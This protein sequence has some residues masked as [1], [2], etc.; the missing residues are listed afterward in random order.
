M[1]PRKV[2]PQKKPRATPADIL[3]MAR[4]AR[5]S[6]PLA[7]HHIIARIVNGEFRI[8]C[9]DERSE[10]LCRL[11]RSLGR[12]DWTMLGYA[13]MSNHVHLLCRAGAAPSDRLVRS[14]HSGF[15]HWLNRTQN[16]LGPVFAERHTTNLVPDA[17]AS[18][19]LAYIHNNPVRAGVAADA[20]ETTWTSHRAYLGLEPAPTWLA[21]EHGLHYSGF[22]A[23]HTGRNAF[24]A[25]A[26]ERMGDRRD[27]AFSGDATDALRESRRAA[28]APVRITD[29]ALSTEESPRRRHDVL[30]TDSTPLRPRWP[31]DV[32][33]VVTAAADM[34][35]V[36]VD[37]L[38]SRRRDRR[39]VG[40]RRLALLVWTGGLGRAQTEM[41]Q[42]L[43]LT[44]AG[45][46][47]LLYRSDAAVARLATQAEVLTAW[48]WAGSADSANK[49]TTGSSLRVSR[50]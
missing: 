43:G 9:D 28:G 16:R 22:D 25:F 6:A 35:G 8:R 50:T 24:H 40:A 27:D 23:T 48:C 10:Y 18:R 14:V 38:V 39:A 4:T 5:L 21:V 30:A 47:H 31:G 34:M 12:C 41:A 29:G 32:T 42:A 20:A 1:R 7:L 26:L 33:T 37:F 15:A 49:R 2:L 19:A 45:A 44:C 13:L 46:S 11:G 17:H 3:G 36:S